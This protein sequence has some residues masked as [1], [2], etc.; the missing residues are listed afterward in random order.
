MKTKGNVGQSEKIQSSGFQALQAS[1]MRYHNMS[2]RIDDGGE[3]MRSTVAAK[4]S[5][6]RW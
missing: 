4:G 1:R 3:S 5:K 2:E 6:K